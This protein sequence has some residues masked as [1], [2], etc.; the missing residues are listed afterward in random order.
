MQERKKV[1]LDAGVLYDATVLHVNPFKCRKWVFF[2]FQNSATY[3]EGKFF[4]AESLQQLYWQ[5]RENN[6]SFNHIE[7]KHMI[8]VIATT[9]YKQFI[10]QCI[11]LSTS[12][13]TFRF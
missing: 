11:A 2:F 6:R 4:E 7:L 12:L 10:C 8:T 3:W 13:E 9:V 5:I 1:N